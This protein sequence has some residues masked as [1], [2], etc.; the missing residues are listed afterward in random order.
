MGFDDL[1]YKETKMYFRESYTF[2][3]LHSIWQPPRC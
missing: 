1:I 3:F 2:R